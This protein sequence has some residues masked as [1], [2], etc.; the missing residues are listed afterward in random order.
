MPPR[1]A[2][3][4]KAKQGSEHDSTVVVRDPVT[5]GFMKATGIH[6]EGSA[7]PT[8]AFLAYMHGI[9]RGQAC[10][11]APAG[12]PG[13]FPGPEW[14]AL[15]LAL[16]ASVVAGSLAAALVAAVRLVARLSQA[17]L[18]ARH[19]AVTRPRG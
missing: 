6:S 18:M 19:S 15:G 4:H 14:V 2:A 1:D 7:Q 8:E 12:L 16:I 13:P 3:S 5:E 10:A 9:T 11:G 17:R